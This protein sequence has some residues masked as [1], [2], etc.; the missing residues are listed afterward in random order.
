MIGSQA[1]RQECANYEETKDWRIVS[2][3]E[4]AM[5][6]LGATALISA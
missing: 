3:C 6:S 1:I 2:T 4:E 5:A